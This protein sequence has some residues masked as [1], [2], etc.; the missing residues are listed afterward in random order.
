MLALNDVKLEMGVLLSIFSTEVKKSIIKSVGS[1]TISE[2]LSSRLIM[3]RPSWSLSHIRMSFGCK[4]L[5]A[6]IISILNELI[7]RQLVPIFSI[8]A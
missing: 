6:G 8:L 3:E 4:T 5:G 2:I 7:V 1:D